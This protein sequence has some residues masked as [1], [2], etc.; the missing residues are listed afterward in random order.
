M[1]F[2]FALEKVFTPAEVEDEE[3]SASFIAR[4]IFD[5]KG[6]LRIIVSRDR[7]EDEELGVLIHVVGAV[8]R[9]DRHPNYEKPWWATDMATWMVGELNS[10]ARVDPPFVKD[11]ETDLVAF[12]NKDKAVHL[13][14]RDLESRRR[15]PGA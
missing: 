9:R 1:R 8:W 5:F 15:E 13:F 3:T 7:Q 14:F 6:G 12:T 4:H 10:I 2:P 11:E